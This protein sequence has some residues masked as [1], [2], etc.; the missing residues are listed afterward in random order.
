MSRPQPNARPVRNADLFFPFWPKSKGPLYENLTPWVF[1]VNMNNGTFRTFEIPAGYIFN[2]ASVPPCLWG[3]PFGY[4]PDGVHR[5]A[6]MEHDF[7]CD[8]GLRPDSFADMMMCDFGIIPIPDPVPHHIAH[9]HFRA[10]MKEYGMRETQV[11]AFGWAV[12][13]LGPRWKID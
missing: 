1:D 5:A 7:L 11:E 6:A 12:K 10:R 8:L 4:T 2:G 9:Q 3:F 13:L